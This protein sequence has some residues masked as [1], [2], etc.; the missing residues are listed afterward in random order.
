M[1][2]GMYPGLVQPN[3]QPQQQQQTLPNNSGGSTTPAG[4]TANGQRHPGGSP[5]GSGATT[6]GTVTPGP[7]ELQ[8]GATNGATPIQL[9]PA[10]IDPQTGALLRSAPPPGG[11]P[12]RLMPPG[13]PMLMNQALAA[14]AAAASGHPQ[15]SLGYG[16]ASNSNLSGSV[17][18]SASRRESM[19]RNSAFSPSLFDQ[20]NKNNKGWPTNYGALGPGKFTTEI[21][22]ETFGKKWERVC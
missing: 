22:G 11:A 2:W 16:A 6:N 21:F 10:Y 14:A 17:T 8:N 18:A 4:G 19:D 9:F 7:P 15:N 1:P 20:Y 5:P 12:L 3:G 13:H